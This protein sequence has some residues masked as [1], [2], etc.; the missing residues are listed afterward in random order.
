MEIRSDAFTEGGMIP[1]KYTCDGENISPPLSWTGIP[2]G[3]RT[4]ALICDDPD[5][6]GGTWVHWLIW[7]LPVT[8]RELVEH[9]PPVELLPGGAEQGKNDF[10]KIGYGGPCPPRGNHRYFFKLFALDNQLPLKH[11]AIKT[12][13]LKAM[14]GH[15]L[16]EA[17]LMGRYQ[18]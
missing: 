6:P 5:A 8:A 4:F 18:R 7:N 12:D 13:L 2:E 17:L 9:I 14:N 1:T 16:S 10:R 15:I 11:G 3:T